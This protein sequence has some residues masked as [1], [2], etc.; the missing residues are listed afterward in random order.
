MSA[1][2]KLRAPTVVAENDNVPSELKPFVVAMAKLLVADLRRRP[3]M[4][5]E[6]G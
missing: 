4:R 1:A 5:R 6:D 3:P 2:P